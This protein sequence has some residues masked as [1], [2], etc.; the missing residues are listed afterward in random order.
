MCAKTYEVYDSINP[1]IEEAYKVLRTNIQFCSN[2]K[3]VKTLS[4]VSCNNKEGKTTISINL[5][6]SLARSGQKVLLIDADMR[7]PMGIKRLGGNNYTGLSNFLLGEVSLEEV[8]SH[9]SI[10]NLYYIACGQRYVN[11]TELVGSERFSE[12]LEIV[13]EIYDMVV[14]DTTTLGNI[15]DAALIASQTDGTLIVV[16]SRELNA[17]KAKRLKEQL[18]KA[19]ANILGVALNKVSKRDY[20]LYYTHTYDF[21]YYNEKGQ[22]NRFVKGRFKRVKQNEVKY[23]D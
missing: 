7:K 17:R 15:I 9:T 4:I 2:E 23:N 14:I 3:K 6:I 1:P 12:F 16:A 21:Y 10:K 20:K 8:V 22:T 11:S 19:N 13:K 5:A 18:E